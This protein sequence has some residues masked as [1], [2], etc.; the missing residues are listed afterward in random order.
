MTNL[1]LVNPSEGLAGIQ[2]LDA[3]RTVMPEKS[4]AKLVGNRVEHHVETIF[5]GRSVADAARELTFVQVPD[6][7]LL[8][9]THFK[10][11]IRDL[12][13]NLKRRMNRGARNGAEECT[14]AAARVMAKLDETGA[15]FDE[16][17]DA[18]QQA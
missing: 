11:K 4:A 3:Q 8:Q 9:R 7:T 10:A 6:P 5:R 2:R 13:E 14:E 15:A 17:N 16:A 12:S 18:L 1:S